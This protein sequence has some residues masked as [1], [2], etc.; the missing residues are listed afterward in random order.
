[1]NLIDIEVQHP[2]LNNVL[3]QG[4]LIAQHQGGA[5]NTVTV[6]HTNDSLERATSISETLLDLIT[7]KTGIAVSAAYLSMGDDSTYHVQLLVSPAA[8]HSPYI[9]AAQLV[10]EQYMQQHT[11]ITIRYHFTIEREYARNVNKTDTQRLMF[12]HGRAASM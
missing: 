6:D 7:K 11:D 4:W 8:F 3:P 2:V 9:R 5:V 1:M 12:L 10:V